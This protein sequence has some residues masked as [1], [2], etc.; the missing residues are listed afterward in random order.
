VWAYRTV[1]CVA[2]GDFKEGK[3]LPW[4]LVMEVAVK[5]I[6]L[7]K[8]DIMMPMSQL[9]SLSDVSQMAPYFLYSALLLTMGTGQKSCSR[10]YGGI[11]DT[12]SITSTRASTSII[13]YR[14]F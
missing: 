5:G 1:L 4:I 8:Q 2:L 14:H 3:R 7:S 12:G 10:E 9:T 6:I 13:L 11:W